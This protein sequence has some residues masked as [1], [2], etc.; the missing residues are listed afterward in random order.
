MALEQDI[1]DA[2][3]DCRFDKALCAAFERKVKS[4][5]V[6]G[7]NFLEKLGSSLASEAGLLQSAMSEA[8]A[9]VLI[10]YV[11]RVMRAMAFEECA[12]SAVQLDSTLQ[13]W[14]RLAA[15][16]TSTTHAALGQAL[17]TLLSVLLLQTRTVSDL[18]FLL[19]LKDPLDVMCDE[20]SAT[21]PIRAL[22]S[23]ADAAPASFCA[24]M[25]RVL[26]DGFH[27]KAAARSSTGGP[28]APAIL[29]VP[30]TT[31]AAASG[32]S[33]SAGASHG[34]ALSSSASP[35]SGQRAAGKASAAAT[36]APGGAPLAP[37]APPQQ[38]DADAA[39]LGGDGG[40][41]GHAQGQRALVA[42]IRTASLADRHIHMVFDAGLWSTLLGLLQRPVARSDDEARLTALLALWAVVTLLPH[43][44]SNPASLLRAQPQLFNALFVMLQRCCREA[45][46]G[47]TAAQ[48]DRLGA[49][50][51]AEKSASAGASFGTGIP[52]AGAGAK[53]GDRHW[54]CVDVQR[55]CAGG[56]G[57]E[58]AASAAPRQAKGP[59]FVQTGQQ[60]KLSILRHLT[61]ELLL[62]LY[63]AFPT[64]VSCYCRRTAPASPSC[65]RA[66]PC[67]LPAPP[68]SPLL[69]LFQYLGTRC[70]AAADQSSVSSGAKSSAAADSDLS[71]AQLVPVL[72]RLRVHPA[73]L[74]MTP[75]AELRS[76]GTPSDM[77]TP[78]GAT[79]EEIREQ[80]HQLWV[81][82]DHDTAQR[83][84]A[85]AL[86]EAAAANKGRQ[87]PVEPGDNTGAPNSV[88]THQSPSE[89]L[90]GAQNA[91]TPERTGQQRARSSSCSAAELDSE[92]RSTAGSSARA[93]QPEEASVTIAE[94]AA[95]QEDDLAA[96][97]K[98]L[99]HL[100]WCAREDAGSAGSGGCGSPPGGPAGW[101]SQTNTELHS[102]FAAADFT[103]LAR[104]AGSS[105]TTAAAAK[106]RRR[107]FLHRLLSPLSMSTPSTPAASASAAAE[108]AAP[109][110]GEAVPPPAT[111]PVL[112]ASVS[113]GSASAT[114][115]GS[116]GA[117]KV[118]CDPTCLRETQLQLTLTSIELLRERR[119]KTELQQQLHELRA[120][121]YETE[122]AAADAFHRQLALQRAREEA[123]AARA[124]ARELRQKLEEA[125]A[126]QKKWALKLQLK[127]TKYA[128]DR[129]RASEA[130]LEQQVHAGARDS[131]LTELRQ[132]LAASA[133]REARA[134]AEAVEARSLAGDASADSRTV[135]ALLEQL[136]NS[137][138][139]AQARGY[140]LDLLATELRDARAQLAEQAAQARR[141]AGKR[142]AKSSSVLPSPLPSP[143][144]SRIVSPAPHSSSSPLTAT[145]P[146]QA[147]DAGGRSAA[148]LE[149]PQQSME[150]MQPMSP[151]PLSARST[152][153]STTTLRDASLAM[154]STSASKGLVTGAT[155]SFQAVGMR[156][157]GA[158]GDRTVAKG[159]AA[160]A[161]DG[162]VPGEGDGEGT[163]RGKP[164]A[165]D[166]IATSAAAAPAVDRSGSE[167]E[168]GGAVVHEDE[169]VLH[170][171]RTSTTAAGSE[172]HEVSAMRLQQRLLEL[173]VSSRRFA[174]RAPAP[175]CPPAWLALT[176]P[177]PS[178]HN[179]RRGGPSTTV[180]Y[181]RCRYETT[182][183][184]CL[185]PDAR[186][187][188]LSPSLWL[189]R[190]AL[191]MLQGMLD[192]QRAL[193][194]A[195]LRAAE[196]KYAVVKSVSV[197]LERKLVR[198]ARERDHSKEQME[199][200]V[201]MEQLRRRDDEHALM[202]EAAGEAAAFTR[203]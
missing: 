149:P 137:D 37:T 30:S 174:A 39:T 198:L 124:E 141:H 75:S 66:D 133:A 201:A 72:S 92:G 58:V 190:P 41:D 99:H 187:A 132:A 115:P 145:S 61:A 7:L 91:G 173:E 146:P 26:L 29:G 5:P 59:Q 3:A 139:L 195:E 56:T 100:I 13:L 33:A 197:A 83:N 158:P 43:A 84:A 117:D 62:H 15:S 89:G 68:L 157:H 27:Q 74:A 180:P 116:H 153:R 121:L 163:V 18:L 142:Q 151:P 120:R 188:D 108:V 34:A 193:S 40:G 110:A 159:H 138:E 80:V 81:G 24:T 47:S 35:G 44:H 17:T 130:D 60:M 166:G 114:A 202:R 46:R 170:G 36:A 119:D 161:T 73:M 143:P 172:E 150:K 177:T 22:A 90:R 196:E 94:V 109:E 1:A 96:L 63:A 42:F 200:A 179:S 45:P 16:A 31:A 19:L 182:C 103:S 10:S 192:R 6:L 55:S 48:A 28:P 144:P 125:R 69:Q 127:M 85:A 111:P 97:Q 4:S 105:R 123:A 134:V 79:P 168:F 98:L 67:T 64:R 165:R 9:A 113:S 65:R 122:F 53:A 129:Q 186:P 2:I 78:Q 95:A 38:P 76:A 136:A 23:F 203:T 8:H 71:F 118:P 93:P 199:R 135:D 126:A 88:R 87:Q 57:A 156:Q 191:C 54:A 52:K 12:E 181:D 128:H 102:V 50:R 104:P 152:V 171:N 189:P 155:S 107:S 185:A 160:D 167:I 140:E 183:G 25:D 112:G 70:S 86:L 176:P 178:Y 101:L 20:K 106:H 131:E 194:A 49:T 51:S 147:D 32:R 77:Y 154:S 169:P 162:R 175:Q 14:A 82:A 11:V 164:R 148:A 184:E 21:I